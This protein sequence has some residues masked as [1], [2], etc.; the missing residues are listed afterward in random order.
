MTQS[1]PKS[2]TAI[3]HSLGDLST[4]PSQKII[5]YVI[6][7]PL[8]DSTAERDSKT[9]SATLALDTSLRALYYLRIASCQAPPDPPRKRIGPR[10]GALEDVLQRLG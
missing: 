1:T 10:Q 4:L 8:E 7:A 3:T 2:T 6:P 9:R 5:P